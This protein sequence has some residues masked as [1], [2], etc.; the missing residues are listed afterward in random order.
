MFII[1]THLIVTENKLPG[2]WS[3]LVEYNILFAE[4]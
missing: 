4:I 1:K 3:G 2:D